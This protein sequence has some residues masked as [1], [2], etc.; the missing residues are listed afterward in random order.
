MTGTE[1]TARPKPVR[2]G[3]GKGKGKGKGEGKGEGKGKGKGTRKGKGKGKGKGIFTQPSLSLNNVVNLN[4]VKN[5]SFRRRTQNNVSTKIAHNIAQ[6]KAIN[7]IEK[8]RIMG[9]KNGLTLKERKALDQMKKGTALNKQVFYKPED[10]NAAFNEYTKKYNPSKPRYVNGNLPELPDS[11]PYSRSNSPPYI[12]PDSPYRPVTP[13]YY[14][15]DSPPYFPSDS[16]PRAP[17]S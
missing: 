7:D 15:S 8:E 9:L 5:V 6:R 12:P 14:R 10:Y 17:S 16:P 11:P 3:K 1:K 13:P 4:L 2:E